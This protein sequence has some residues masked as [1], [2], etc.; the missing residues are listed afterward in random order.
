MKIQSLFN[1]ER[2]MSNDRLCSASDASVEK[3]I[4]GMS[5]AGGWGVRPAGTADELR[6][7]GAAS[8]ASGWL[9][10]GVACAEVGAPELV[11]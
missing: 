7:A 8:T 3:T 5:T 10:R 11:P 1:G 2:V 6:A 4:A 9:W